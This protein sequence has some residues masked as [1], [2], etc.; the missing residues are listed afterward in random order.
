MNTTAGYKWLL[1]GR[2]N[3][4]LCDQAWQLIE[5]LKLIDQ[6]EYRDIDIDLELIRRFSDKVPVLA[7]ADCKHYIVWPFDMESVIAF[8]RERT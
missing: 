6:C 8:I 7:T 1:L 3:C 5:M 2:E 4:E